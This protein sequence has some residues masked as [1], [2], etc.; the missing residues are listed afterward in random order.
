MKIDYD[1][2]APNYELTRTVEPIVYA[3]LCN[4]LE[5]SK[6]DLVLDFGCGTGNYLNKILKDYQIQP[7]GLEPS[8]EMRRFAQKKTKSAYFLAGD[9]TRIPFSDSFFNKIYCTD[10]VHHIRELDLFFSNIF[11]VAATGAKFCICTESG[12]QLKEKYW[13]KYFPKILA[14]DLDRFHS[15]DELIS[16]GETAGWSYCEM[17]KTEQEMKAPISYSFWNRV[18]AKSLSVLQ[19]LTDD[20]Y[21]FG[22]SLMKKD[23]EERLIIP[24]IEGYTFLLFEKRK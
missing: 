24:Q 14:L 9:H 15:I 22:M 18:K 6:D 2:Y 13:N 11:R 21:Q 10:V 1:K 23:F 17:I 19:L 7:Y 16:E 3:I 4:I 12:D 20:E 5:F 8:E